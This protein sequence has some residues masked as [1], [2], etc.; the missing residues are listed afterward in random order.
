MSDWGTVVDDYIDIY[1][2]VTIYLQKPYIID[3]LEY[4]TF[5]LNDGVRIIDFNIID[6]INLKE[7]LS[8]YAENQYNEK[9][10]KGDTGIRKNVSRALYNVYL[11]TFDPFIEEYLDTNYPHRHIRNVNARIPRKILNITKVEEDYFYIDIHRSNY[12]VD[13]VRNVKRNLTNFD[14]YPTL[15]SIGE[16]LLGMK[17]FDS[18]ALVIWNIEEG[19]FDEYL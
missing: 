17:K 18:Y 1:N 10:I 6:V 2:K 14:D 15:K 9:R 4:D 12:T 13:D 8:F 5:I 11:G 16:N 3:R 19:V 7:K